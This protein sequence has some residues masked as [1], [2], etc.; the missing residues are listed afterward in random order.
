MNLREN[1]LGVDLKVEFNPQCSLG[2]SA[3][4]IVIF[5]KGISIHMAIIFP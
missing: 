4:W 2:F 1:H 3:G 5:R